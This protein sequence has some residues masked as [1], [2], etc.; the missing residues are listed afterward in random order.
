MAKCLG[1][2]VSPT[3]WPVILV[4]LIV[5]SS[6]RFSLLAHRLESGISI[7]LRLG[8]LHLHTNQSNLF[9]FR[10]KSSKQLFARLSSATES[11]EPNTVMMLIA[12][13]DTE[14]HD[15]PYLMLYLSHPFLLHCR[16]LKENRPSFKPCRC[17][18]LA[19]VFPS[20]V[21]HHVRRLNSSL[22]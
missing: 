15:Y 7:I 12:A 14:A 21:V 18:T 1:R 3:W 9:G 10:S 20:W 5:Y 19:D 22:Q 13:C 2:K 8:L 17:G 16:Q 4:L 6:S 11:T